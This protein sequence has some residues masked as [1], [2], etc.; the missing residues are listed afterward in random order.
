[1]NK[2]NAIL[3]AKI[4]RRYSFR[5]AGSF[6]RIG[7]DAIKA[8]KIFLDIVT[9]NKANGAASHIELAGFPHHSLD[10]LL[11]KP[12][13]GRKRMFGLFVDSWRPQRT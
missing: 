10:V 2:Y 1:M 7:E 13:C 8:S 11:P 5:V 4:R 9:D 6:M 12:A 3:K